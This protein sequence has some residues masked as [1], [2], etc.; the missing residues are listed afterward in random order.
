M[1]FSYE[2][3]LILIS[4]IIL[5]FYNLFLTEAAVY[6]TCG[7]TY[8]NIQ[9]GTIIYPASGLYGINE[10]C[11]WVFYPTVQMPNVRIL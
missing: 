9:D 7:G 1:H 6:N 4:V 10:L 5:I 8:T 2:K 3:F 11:V